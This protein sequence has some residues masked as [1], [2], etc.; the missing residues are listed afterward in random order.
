[1]SIVLTG[2]MGSGKSTVGIMLAKSLDVL[3]YD[4]DQE[5]EKQQG[6]SILELFVTKGETFFRSLETEYLKKLLMQNDNVILS[7]GGGM[8]LQEQNRE[9]LHQIGTVVYLKT[10]PNMI[11]S[12]VK[13]DTKRPLLQC[14]NPYDKIGTMLQEREPVYERGAD[15]ILTTDQ[16]TVRNL[17]DEII[18]TVNNYSV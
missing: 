8:P 2:Y 9:L 11:Y 18:R 17:V 12:R 10:S 7:T 6:C 5:I 3:F 4:S 15:I 16:K 1:M 13:N 14:D